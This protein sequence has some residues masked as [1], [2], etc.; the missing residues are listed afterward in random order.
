MTS[1]AVTVSPKTSVVRIAQLMDGRAISGVP[2][3]TEKGRVIGIVTDADLVS[4]NTR[5][6]PPEIPD[7]LEEGV[8]V[9]PPAEFRRRLVHK[10]GTLAK[11]VM[12][13]EVLTVG[14][15]EDVETLASILVRNG[16]N[17]VPVVEAGRLAGVVSRA[18]VIRWMTRADGAKDQP[19][20]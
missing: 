4:R 11:D 8:Q 16:I 20:P 6:E 18:D 3:V 5:V 9:G 1:D 14:P 7:L 12:T 15:D 19:T 13:E 2:V 10:V 17:M